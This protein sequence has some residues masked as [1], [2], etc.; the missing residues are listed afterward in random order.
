MSLS[1]LIVEYEIIWLDQNNNQDIALNGL[2]LRKHVVC[3]Q[4]AHSTML[5]LQ[6]GL[7]HSC[8]NR[9]NILRP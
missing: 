1:A 9:K 4:W 6:Y 5:V 3:I 7:S 8:E 2:Q